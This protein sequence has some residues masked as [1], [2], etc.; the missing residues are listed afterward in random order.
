[1][2]A[3]VEVTGRMKFG[4]LKNEVP[5]ASEDSEVTG[6]DTMDVVSVSLG[7]G[8]SVV[9]PETGENATIPLPS[10]GCSDNQEKAA[11]SG[12]TELIEGARNKYLMKNIR[13]KS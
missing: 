9:R 10:S 3:I 4:C 13:C 2:T 11:F 1:M 12:R 7:G 5:E 6:G 8:D